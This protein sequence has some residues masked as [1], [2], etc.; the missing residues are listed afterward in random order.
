M[1]LYSFLQYEKGSKFLF[2]KERFIQ[3]VG[4]EWDLKKRLNFFSFDIFCYADIFCSVWLG[5]RPFLFFFV[6]VGLK[7]SSFV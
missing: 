3:C 2:K 5:A 1:D 4:N 6:Y 7:S